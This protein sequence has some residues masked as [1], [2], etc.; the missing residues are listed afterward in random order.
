MAVRTNKVEL[1]ASFFVSLKDSVD[2]VCLHW[3]GH[4]DNTAGKEPTPLCLCEAL[5]DEHHEHE[6]EYEKTEREKDD[7]PIVLSRDLHPLNFELCWQDRFCRH[8]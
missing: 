8:N 1:P 2:G 7:I 3:P 5:R 4:D 6:N